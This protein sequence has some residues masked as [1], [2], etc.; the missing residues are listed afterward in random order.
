MFV[1]RKGGVFVL[2]I[3]ALVVMVLVV[4]VPV[5]S[6]FRP[7]PYCNFL[8]GHCAGRHRRGEVLVMRH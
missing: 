4:M 7:Q 2:G 3:M 1:L 5:G 6:G 8:Q